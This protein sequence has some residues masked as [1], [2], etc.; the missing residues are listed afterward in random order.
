MKRK[1]RYLTLL[2]LACSLGGCNQSDQ[3]S[4]A[5]DATKLA[6]TVGT[7]AKNAELAG[8]VNLVLNNWKG[9]DSAVTVQS[10]NG[11]ITLEGSMKN[12]AEKRKV[13]SIV[14]QIRGV[15]KVIDRLK[16]PDEER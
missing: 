7:A 1:N 5:T 8:K 16:S 4:L 13:L 11:V 9:V 2:A 15:N 12:H 3:K 6:S 10:E 14:N